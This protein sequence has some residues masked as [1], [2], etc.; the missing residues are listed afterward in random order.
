MMVRSV[1][2][3][4]AMPARANLAPDRVGEDLPLAQADPPAA[5]PGHEEL[6]D[7]EVGGTRQHVVEGLDLEVGRELERE[8]P[9]MCAT[10]L[11]WVVV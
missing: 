8:A 9:R 5:D 3:A 10:S 2:T 11:A 4:S 1:S 6:G 7:Q